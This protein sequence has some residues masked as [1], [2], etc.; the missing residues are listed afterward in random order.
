MTREEAIGTIRRCCPK[1]SDSECDF[2]TAMRFL[3]PEL[4]ESEDERIRKALIDIFCSIDKKDWR[5]IPTERILAYLEKQKEPTTEELYAEAG[6]TEKEY[7]A[8]TMKMVRAMR[9]KQKDQKPAEWSEELKNELAKK[10]LD[11][12]IKGREDTMREMSDFI[13]SHFNGEE[14]KGPNSPAINIPTWTPPCYYGGPCT[15]PFKDC[16]NC[17]RANVVIS[18]NTTSGTATATLDGNTSATDGEPH[19]PS[20]TD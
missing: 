13:K 14:A 11:G 9:E 12:Y 20:F 6:T 7:I 1:I 2:E 10:H 4:A 17:P 15:N 5:G 19:N 3:I 16:I 18:P 8:N